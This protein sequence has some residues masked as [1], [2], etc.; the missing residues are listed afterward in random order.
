MDYLVMAYVM[1]PINTPLDWAYLLLK[2]GMDQA[3]LTA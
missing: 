1:E 2:L 3:Q